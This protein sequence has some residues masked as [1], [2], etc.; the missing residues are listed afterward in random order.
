M[1]HIIINQKLK[2]NQY[3]LRKDFDF[4]DRNRFTEAFL[5]FTVCRSFYSWNGVKPFS[6][7][8]VSSHQQVRNHFSICFLFPQVHNWSDCLLRKENQRVEKKESKWMSV[9]AEEAA[10]SSLFLG[11]QLRVDVNA[12]PQFH[13]FKLAGDAK[14]FF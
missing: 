4:Q 6:R 5:D 2:I 13:G 3:L 1:T 7:L 11:G 12:N 14:S 10:T 8:F 9:D